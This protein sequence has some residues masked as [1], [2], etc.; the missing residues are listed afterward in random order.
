MD[1]ADLRV[2]SDVEAYGW[3]V[4]KIAGDEHAPPWAF[5][6]GLEHSFTHPEVLACGMDLDLLHALIN[7]VGEQVKRGRRFD[8][9]AQPEGV[10]E[11]HPPAFR[12]VLAK[13]H[14]AFVGNA[15]WFYR[16]RPF[17]VLQCFW[18]DAQGHLPWEQDFDAAWLG[19]QPL[20]FREDEEAALGKELAELLRREGAL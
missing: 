6:I 11:H 4:A 1:E 3:H 18:P 16:G 14:G 9:A 5:S 15:A 13:W 8:D 10:L 12:P 17:R 19:R 2:R 7:Q 20:L